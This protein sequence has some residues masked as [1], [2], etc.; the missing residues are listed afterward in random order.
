M[1]ATRSQHL[2]RLVALYIVCALAT[3]A[4]AG[5]CGGAF[6]DG[7]Y[8]DVKAKR[9]NGTDPNVPDPDRFY[10][11]GL[12]PATD[13]PIRIS[14]LQCQYICHRQWRYSSTLPV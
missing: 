4:Y 5:S 7:C 2:A 9:N 11:L 6:T 13:T 12:T 1:A 8:E 3:I 14:L 10:S